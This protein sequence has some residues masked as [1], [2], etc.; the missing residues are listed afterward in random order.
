MYLSRIKIDTENRR[1]IRPLTHLGAYHDWVEKSFPAEIEAGVRRRHLWRIDPLYGELYLMVLSEEKPA[2]KEFSKYGVEGTFRSKS[3]DHLLASIQNGQVLRFRVTANPTYADPQPGKERGKVYPHV[4]IEQ[5]RNWLIKKSA[6]AGFE[7][8]KRT[9]DMI[10]DAGDQY[11][12]DIVHRDHPGLNRKGNRVVHL[13]RVTFEGIL[14]VT[15][16][17]VFR[18]TLIQGLGREKAFG[19]GLMTVLSEV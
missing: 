9:N 11:L 10:P 12:F 19:M 7:I 1:K 17:D 4:T 16:S 2:L 13:S 3:Y 5:Q 15:D 18:Q 8:M 14:K 6:N